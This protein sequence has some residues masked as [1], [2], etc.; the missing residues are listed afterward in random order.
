MGTRGVAFDVQQLLKIRTSIEIRSFRNV[1]ELKQRQS[2]KVRISR[3]QVS[4]TSKTE[5]T[6]LNVKATVEFLRL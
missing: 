3:P 2:V 5:S 1:L 4:Y 6:S